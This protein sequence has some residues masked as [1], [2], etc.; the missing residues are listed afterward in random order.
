MPHSVEL[1]LTFE[2]EVCTREAVGK[3]CLLSFGRMNDMSLMGGF[4]SAC[5][6]GL[7][8]GVVLV[9]SQSLC[10][11]LRCLS[12]GEFGA[13]GGGDEGVGDGDKLVAAVPASAVALEIVG[14]SALY[15]AIRQTCLGVDSALVVVYPPRENGR[16]LGAVDKTLGGELL[17]ELAG[18][19]LVAARVHEPLATEVVGEQFVVLPRELRECRGGVSNRNK[20]ITSSGL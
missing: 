4:Q 13:E 12:L 1:V 8:I 10:R 18:G 3:E 17:T 15:H 9:F 2:F 20:E 16:Y 5:G 6:I 19:L 14:G 11:L 7:H